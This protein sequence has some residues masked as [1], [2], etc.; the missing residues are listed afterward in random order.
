MSGVHKRRVIVCWVEEGYP[1]GL[2]MPASQ[3]ALGRRVPP[4][5]T[6]NP[7]LP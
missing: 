4:S 6:Q 2:E 1:H 3:A 7:N 5:A